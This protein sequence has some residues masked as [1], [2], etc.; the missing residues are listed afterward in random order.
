MTAA[1]NPLMSALTGGGA[2]PAANAPKQTSVLGGFG[3]LLGSLGLTAQGETQALV[4]ANTVAESVPELQKNLGALVQ[5]ASA[6]LQ[7]VEGAEGQ[8]SVEEALPLLTELTDIVAQVEEIAA[9]ALLEKVGAL[10]EAQ[11]SVDGADAGLKLADFGSIAPEALSSEE[12]VAAVVQVAQTIEAALPR[13]TE[14]SIGASIA[15]LPSRPESPSVTAAQNVPQKDPVAAP[16]PQPIFE[17]PQQ[18]T[19]SPA[20]EGAATQVEVATVQTEAVEVV[21]SLS[22]TVAVSTTRPLTRTSE[23]QAAATPATVETASPSVR[24]ESVL[25]V[26]EAVTDAA[27]K[28]T[29]VIS[30]VDRTSGQQFELPKELLPVV[31]HEFTATGR[32]FAQQIE[33]VQNSQ[34]PRAAESQTA[35]F[36]SAIVNQVSAVT[37]D[38]GVTRVELTPR[39]LGAMEIEL[40]TNSDGSLSVVVRAENTSVLNSLR[41]ERALLAEILPDTAQGSLEFQEFESSGENAQQNEAGAETYGDMS[42]GSAEAASDEATQP[43]ATIGNGQLD[44]MT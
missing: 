7:S 24:P 19:V 13:T 29:T 21:Q 41:E 20:V 10:L 38:E 43:T 16:K 26:F 36:A 34:P 9:P 11:V 40:S 6:L 22:S 3:A 30:L 15:A 12:L 33:T 25:K 27:T 39:G 35:R 32:D 23:G 14:P 42:D 4:P 31:P 28:S 37:L 2:S 1:V 5:K 17:V 44:L 8:V 18:P